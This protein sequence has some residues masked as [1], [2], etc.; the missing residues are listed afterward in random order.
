MNGTSGMK[1]RGFLGA[2]LGV[3]GASAL[4]RKAADPPEDAGPTGEVAEV[5]AVDPGRK[6][7]QVVRGCYVGGFYY[8]AE[9]D[10]IMPDGSHVRRRCRPT[11][12]CVIEMNCEG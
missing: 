6:E 11:N 12:G 8:I 4:L 2:V 9:F 7:I 3:V 10:E 5:L 1:R